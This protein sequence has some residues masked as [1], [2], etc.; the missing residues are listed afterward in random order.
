MENKKLTQ[1]LGEYPFCGMVA[2]ED[3]NINVAVSCCNC[4]EIEV[5]QNRV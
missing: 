3:S 4:K 5:S 2:W 1:N